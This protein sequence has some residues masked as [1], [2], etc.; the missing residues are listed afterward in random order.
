MDRTSLY[1]HL[2]VP[3]TFAFRSC[4]VKLQHQLS[5]YLTSEII[6]LSTYN[7]QQNC[8]VV[9]TFLSIG[10]S[11]LTMSL[12]CTFLSFGYPK[13]LSKTTIFVVDLM[14]HYRCLFVN[15]FLQES[16]LLNF[17]LPFYYIDF[18]VYFKM[19]VIF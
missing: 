16:W 17:I 12:E 18:C 6:F 19:Y 3:L 8:L 14:I 1:F 9:C 15:T 2:P 11:K 4:D 10:Y 5:M 7:T 13:Y